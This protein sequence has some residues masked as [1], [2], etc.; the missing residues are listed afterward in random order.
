MRRAA[1]RVFGP[2]P[3][4][5]W[6]CVRARARARSARVRKP[7]E[8]TAEGSLAPERYAERNGGYTRVL[9]DGFRRG[10]NAEMGI[11]ELV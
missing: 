6:Q 11:I 2:A 4:C 5:R 10:D 8:P 7:P 9:K 3:Q 1:P